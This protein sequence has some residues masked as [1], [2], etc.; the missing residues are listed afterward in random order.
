MKKRETAVEWLKE[1]IIVRKNGI[2]NSIPLVD[3]FE[4]ALEIEK[5]QIMDAWMS[6]KENDKFGYSIM[7]DA[8][9]YYEDTFAEKTP[10][11]KVSD[12]LG[13]KI[14]QLESIRTYKEDEEMSEADKIEER[15]I[16]QFEDDRQ[17]NFDR[18]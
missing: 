3:L 5:A 12:F 6:G 18:E 8:E 2:D 17:S 11:E 9:K 16:A 10:L 4:Q 13:D 1:Q 7:V 14:E 15:G